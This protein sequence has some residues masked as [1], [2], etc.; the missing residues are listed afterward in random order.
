MC[1]CLCLCLCLCVCVCVTGAAQ[2]SH[3]FTGGNRHL[4]F[5]PLHGT[6]N[7]AS[8][9]FSG[10]CSH[11]HTTSKTNARTHI[12]TR[13]EMITCTHSHSLTDYL[14]ASVNVNTC[15]YCMYVCVVPRMCASISEYI[16]FVRQR[17]HINVC[18]C[19]CVCA[20]S[21]I[22]RRK[23]HEKRVL[24]RRRDA[25]QLQQHH[26]QNH[27]S[28]CSSTTI[29]SSLVQRARPARLRASSRSPAADCLFKGM[30]FV[31]P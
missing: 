4:F 29:S 22:E 25:Q 23:E 20:T 7:A 9:I 17:R 10:T 6:K 11:T 8:Y 24:R 3:P 18:V 31:Y 30:C 13:D 5:C 19:V 27:S 14:Y 12:H 16:Y 1:L 15:V 21:Q 28:C 2:Q 26:Q